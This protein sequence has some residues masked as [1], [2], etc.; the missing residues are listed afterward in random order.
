MVNIVADGG[1]A[2]LAMG[3]ESGGATG[4]TATDFVQ[5]ILLRTQGVDYV[6]GLTTGATPWNDQGVVDAWKT[7]VDWANKYGAG[8][9]D[10]AI[11]TNFG[12]AILQPFKDPAEAWM[13]KQSGFAGSATI[14]PNI[15]DFVYGQDFAFFVLPGKGEEAPPMQ[16]SGDI[17]GAFTSAPATQAMVA[18]LSS[19]EGAAAW[20]AAGFDLSPNSAVDTSA[21]E[22]PISA[23][24]AKTL[25]EASGV[26]Y[27]VGDLMPPAV[28]QAEF[29]GITAA[30]GGGDVTEIL[31]NIQSLVEQN[32]ATPEASG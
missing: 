20:A 27:D 22:N 19:S 12:D 6:A 2:P 9:A 14:Q 24:K 5:D 15:P 4:W 25:A 7:Y 29:D 17:L 10:G 30:V 18:Y 31:N 16:V 21:Y 8:G 32:M 1:P 11:T 13:V 3:F 26:S 23:D 28:G